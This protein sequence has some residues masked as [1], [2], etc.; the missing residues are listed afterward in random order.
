MSFP[1]HLAKNLTLTSLAFALLWTASAE[2]KLGIVSVAANDVTP[3]AIGDS[4]GLLATPLTQKLEYTAY[5]AHIPEAI[6]TTNGAC[7]IDLALE[8]TQEAQGLSDRVRDPFLRIYSCNAAQLT[9]AQKLREMIISDR[10]FRLL[11][12]RDTLTIVERGFAPGVPEHLLRIQM[13]NGEIVSIDELGSMD[14]SAGKKV[15]IIDQPLEILSA[16]TNGTRGI[17]LDREKVTAKDRLSEVCTEQTVGY[18][19]LLSVNDLATLD[20]DEVRTIKRIRLHGQRI[21]QMQMGLN[22]SIKSS[23]D[24]LKSPK[25][26]GYTVSLETACKGN[27]E[28]KIWIPIQTIADLDPRAQRALLSALVSIHGQ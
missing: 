14:I 27:R 25:I 26:G 5:G 24:S 17:M 9:N 8:Y 18:G 1:I 20:L 11:V 21:Q 28:N 6:G 2:A 3:V 22:R 15:G 4:P 7:I 16:L 23:F 10:S 13:E 12:G 19:I